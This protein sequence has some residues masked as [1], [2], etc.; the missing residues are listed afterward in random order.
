LAYDNDIQLIYLKTVDFSLSKWRM[1]SLIDTV[2]FE[3]LTQTH[4]AL[5][6]SRSMIQQLSLSL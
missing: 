1:F 2:M 4:T 5:R 3:A 6:I